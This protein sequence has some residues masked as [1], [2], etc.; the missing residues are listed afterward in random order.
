LHINVKKFQAAIHTIQSL[1][2]EKQT[3]LLFVDN[4]V[5]Y[6]YLVK[7]G[8]GKSHM[9][10]SSKNIFPLVCGEKDQ[11]PSEMGPLKGDVGRQI[12]K[13]GFQK[14]GIHLSQRHFQ[15]DSNEICKTHF[16][17]NRYICLPPGTKN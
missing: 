1:A 2:K 8:G 12:V 17:T 3:V 4:Q 15:S 7:G 16:I 10:F 11:P 5:T 13:V 9:N 14:G 6:F